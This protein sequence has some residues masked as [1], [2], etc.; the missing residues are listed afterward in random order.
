MAL[1]CPNKTTKYFDPKVY[2]YN[3]IKTFHRHHTIIHI[4]IYNQYIYTL[5]INCKFEIN[6]RLSQASG[7]T[8][9]DLFMKDVKQETFLLCLMFT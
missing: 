4:F 7:V 1:L 5:K 3:V 2:S 6:T 8:D 9:I